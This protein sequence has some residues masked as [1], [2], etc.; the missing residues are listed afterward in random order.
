MTTMNRVRQCPNCLKTLK[1]E[2]KFC[3]NDCYDTYFN[4]RVKMVER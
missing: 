3:N 4:D 2:K 1:D